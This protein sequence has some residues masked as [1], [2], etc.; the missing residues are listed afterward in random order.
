M[1]E[2]QRQCEFL[3]SLILTGESSHT[4]IYER[5]KKA[6]CDE[7]CV[8]IALTLVSLLAL[9]SLL[10]LG[11]SAVLLPSFFESGTPVLV[12]LFCA[13]GLA[14]LFS[15]IVFTG[16]WLWYRKLVDRVYEECRRLVMHHLGFDRPPLETASLT[17]ILLDNLYGNGAKTV[18]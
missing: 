7:R 5:I 16:Y 17:P 10:G 9:V 13:L 4:E 2:R 11:Y 14:S 3:K 18:K 8:R 15:T 1:S 12:R 6:E